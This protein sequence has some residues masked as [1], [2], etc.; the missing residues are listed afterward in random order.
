MTDLGGPIS[1]LSRE[2]LAKGFGTFEKIVFRRVRRDGKTSELTREILDTGDGAAVL[3]YDAERGTILLIR[4][5]RGVAYLKTGAETIVE[6]CAGK[7]EGADPLARIVKEAEEETGLRLRATPRKVFTG[8]SS[9]GS[10]CEILHYFVV[11]YTA[12][13]R[14]S[15]GGGLVGE[16][17]DIEVFEITLAEAL[18]M[19]ERGAIVD[20]KTI[21]LLYY[22]Q[23][24]GL[25]AAAHL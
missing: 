3:P 12:E 7:L 18:A 24:T 5:F 19:V 14:V 8:Y 17:E 11:P 15:E 6:V 25:L 13:E 21:A 16:G 23:A 9:P 2:L 22:A 4:Q 20:T 1:I 10:F